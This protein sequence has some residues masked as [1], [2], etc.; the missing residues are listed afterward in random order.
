VLLTATLA[1]SHGSAAAD[2]A[3]AVIE[4]DV[5]AVEAHEAVP[6]TATAPNDTTDASASVLLGPPRDT[7]LSPGPA[8]SFAALSDGNTVIP[9]DVSGAVGL[10]NQLMVAT[11]ADVQVQN[12]SG[13]VLSN[14][15]EATFWSVVV[16]GAVIRYPHVLYD[17]IRNRWIFAALARGGGATSRLLV[18][19][20][21]NLDATGQWTLYAVNLDPSNA[22]FGCSPTL[23]FDNNAI[24]AQVNMFNASNGAFAGSQVYAFDKNAAYTGTTA[25]YQLFS[26]PADFGAPQVPA[27]TYDDVG[28]E[29][30]L[31]MLAGNWGGLG[32]LQLWTLD[33]SVGS[34]TLTPG[35]EVDIVPPWDHTA[36][37]DTNFAPQ[38]GSATK[39]YLGDSQ[40]QSVVYRN[41]TV[42][43]A[44]TVFLPAGAP[45]RSAVQW[46]QLDPFTGD[47][48]QVGRIEDT[49]GVAPQVFYAFPSIAVNANDD[50]LIG[51]SRFSVQQYASANY[52]LR[53]AFDP[54]GTM[55]DERVLKA[56]QAPYFKTS[57][58]GT[59]NPWGIYSSTMLDPANDN[60][61]W[62]VQEYA[63][64]ASGGVD[65]WGTWWGRIVAPA[66]A[67]PTATPTGPTPT[68][69]VTTT[70]TATVTPTATLTATATATPTETATPTLTATITAT[71][72]PTP[73][74]TATPGCGVEPQ[75]GC[76]TPAVAGKASVAL[77]DNADDTKD[78]LAWN[79]V[80]ASATARAEF[81]DPLAATAYD[82]CIYDATPML[83]LSASIPPAGM[84]GVKPCWKAARHGFVYANKLLMPD[85]LQ[86]LTL[87]EGLLDGKA[88]ITAK[89]KGV[90]LDMPPLP[91]SPPIRVQLKN[92]AGVCW[93]ATYSAPTKSDAGQF[94]AHAD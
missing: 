93:E 82:L 26:L 64:P 88:R 10:L 81:G 34:A 30:L 33:G 55:E 67:T 70:G 65:R 1:T 8:S 27:I 3:P 36:P 11:N 60:A 50:A 63:A 49:N 24:V 4:G 22:T 51:Y 53:R 57:V 91:L 61:M 76:R 35:T 12:R 69:T 14:V 6:F 17:V 59:L 32:A 58:G 13:T 43:A 44:H 75:A 89:G 29:V 62:T 19:A 31:Q 23:G 15:P 72:S 83:V 40:M 25:F 45:T 18:A 16:S 80:K 9:P 92:T 94:K 71:L 28:T 68:P 20:S 54:P 79:L 84:C 73:T 37:G 38:S 90:N 78:K 52:A 41:G 85:G 7:A 5:Q 56:G 46:M 42:W 47:V 39:V 21:R 2:D 48:L 86:Q 74:V 77:I 66:I 87:A